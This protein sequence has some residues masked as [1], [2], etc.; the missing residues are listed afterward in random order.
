M[1]SRVL[2]FHEELEITETNLREQQA[3][4]RRRQLHLPT[5]THLSEASPAL[6]AM[7][8]P[9]DQTL[10]TLSL[11]DHSMLFQKQTNI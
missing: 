2:A 8:Q 10:L 5:K 11:S 4:E 6:H 7:P 9:L 3:T 1:K